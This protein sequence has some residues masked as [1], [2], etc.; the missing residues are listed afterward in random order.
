MTPLP[1]RRLRFE[2]RLTWLGGRATLE[3]AAAECR[4]P[5]P[6]RPRL[7]VTDLPALLWEASTWRSA[8]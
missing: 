4:K 2:L 8:S 1:D 3:R 6:S 7:G 5:N